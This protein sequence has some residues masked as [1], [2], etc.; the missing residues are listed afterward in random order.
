MAPH[1][2]SIIAGN[3]A[4]TPSVLDEVAGDVVDAELDERSGRS[5]REYVRLLRVYRGVAASCFGVIF[6]AVLLATLLAPRYY[7]A[8]TR[9][10]L[11]RHSPI[12]L[13]LQQNVVRIDDSEREVNGGSSFLITQVATL[14][15][16]DLAER[17]IRTHRLATEQAFLHP[18]TERQGLLA[19]GGRLANLL[20]PRGWDAEPTL[21]PQ[22]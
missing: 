14:K 12:Q 9:L 16:R 15:S 13:Q 20:R 6:G 5:A 10:Q 17:V 11:A 8:T 19:L 1:S 2:N 3:R 18:G 4:R 21:Q 22:A 7:T